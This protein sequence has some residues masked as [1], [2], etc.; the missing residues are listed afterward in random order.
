[1]LARLGAKAVALVAGVALIFFGVGLIGFGIAAGF[2]S[3]VGRGWGD[4]IAGAI[5]LLSPAI[6]AL[7][8]LGRGARPASARSPRMNSVLT[9]LFTALA[10]ETP[11]VAV[12]GAT[13]ASAAAMF[14]N[15][16]KA[17]K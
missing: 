11:W 13:L 2:A 1:M 8:V 16:N 17:R 15:R 5:F 9:A 10:R 7:A 12:A 6:W 14:L 3:I 4:A